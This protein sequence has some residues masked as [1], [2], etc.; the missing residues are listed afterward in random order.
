MMKLAF[1]SRF[2]E[3]IIK[4]T[5][6]RDALCGIVTAL[7]AGALLSMAFSA[8]QGLQAKTEPFE[9]HAGMLLIEL[10]LYRNAPPQIARVEKLAQGRVTALTPGDDMLE[11][12]DAQGNTLY[13]TT[14][15]P[16]FLRAT[17]LPVPTDQVTLLLVAPYD[18][19]VKD[20]RV[21]TSQGVTV[22]HME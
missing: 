5:P 9:T 17:H 21:T 4:R 11:L 2:D 19:R 1:L 14:F 7:L 16:N 6:A 3:A 20:V 10:T 18:S 8:Q 12:L 13:T 15:K 22:F